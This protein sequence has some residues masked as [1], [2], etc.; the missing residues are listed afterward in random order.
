MTRRWRLAVL[1]AALVLVA[2]VA[3]PVSTGLLEASG[4]RA[5]GE[6]RASVELHVW[7][8]WNAEYFYVRARVGEGR[9]SRTQIVDLVPS[10]SGRAYANTWRLS[11]DLPPAEGECSF[12]ET[13][14]RSRRA[15]FRLNTGPQSGG[16]AFHIGGGEFVTAAH[17]LET[18]PGD[19]PLTLTNH[20]HVFEDV[21]VV[22]AVGIEADGDVALLRAA[23]VPADV[24]ALAW[25]E[26]T[27]AQPVALLG[28]PADVFLGG[29]LHAQIRIGPAD[30][31]VVLGPFT[32][33]LWP[34][35]PSFLGQSGG[36]VVDT[37]GRVLGV[38][39]GFF[40][41]EY[42]HAR[43]SPAVLELLDV[44]RADPE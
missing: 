19:R 5:A 3:V 16:T 32:S 12:A 34:R 26:L 14:E 31:A 7:R 17:V 40:D 13:L 4:G 27:V 36:P 25:G 29:V 28:Y 37:C 33:D 43:G 15:T 35:I 6:R 10:Q 21:D 2:A 24:P 20:A 18:G 22:G 42:S 39:L 23:G 44:I 11:V 1:V 30:P 8:W 41:D 38:N 9:W